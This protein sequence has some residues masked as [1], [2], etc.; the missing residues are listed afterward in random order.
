MNPPRFPSIEHVWVALLLASVVAAAGLLPLAPWDFW[1]HAAV[2]REIVV[3]G[4]IPT[5]DTFSYTAVGRPYHYQSWLSEI[6][7]YAALALGGPAGAIWLRVGVLLFAFGLLLWL[8]AAASCGTLRLA[9]VAT[10]IAVVGSATNWAVRP[11]LLSLPLFV[12]ELALLW[13]W[14]SAVNAPRPGSAPP[15][16]P[17]PLL[18]AGWANL[19]GAFVLG[20]ALPA[21]LW[22]G[23]FLQQ[24]RLTPALGQLAGWTALAGLAVTLNPRGPEILG[25]V[26]TL[27]TDPPSQTFIIEWRPPTLATAEGRLFFTALVASAALFLW[28]RRALRLSDW[29]WWAAFAVLASRGLR[30]VIW[31]FLLLAPLVA[32]A[33]AAVRETEEAEH[34]VVRPLPRWAAALNAS[35]I[36]LFAVL[37][38]LA[39]PVFKA[40]LPLPPALQGLV[41]ADTPVAAAVALTERPPRHLFHDMGHGSYLIWQWRGSP[42]V[43]IDPRVELYPLGL[44]EDYATVVVADPGWQTILERWQVDTLL[45]DRSRQAPLIAAAS[46]AGWRERWADAHSVIFERETRQ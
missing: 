3:T 15:L 23:E 27:L 46:T 35:L 30:Y 6:I 37:A 12:A 17:L 38:L 7:L 39:T 34:E 1:W 2:G 28:Q 32:L 31:F 40:R 22:L 16:W 43:F 9:V 10:S 33:L 14:R 29:L 24:R 36:G 5:T 20:L 13:R 19:H 8:S 44:W 42:P 26:W 21:L 4:Q 41:T 25:Y 11:Q 45:L 18:T